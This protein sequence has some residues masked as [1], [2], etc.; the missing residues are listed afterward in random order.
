MRRI[1]RYTA[2]NGAK[3]GSVLGKKGRL[4]MEGILGAH[5]LR[6]THALRYLQYIDN[7]YTYTQD[8]IQY[9]PLQYIHIYI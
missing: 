9:I 6:Y 1:P 3:M 8:C 4:Q 7:P 2:D 5:T